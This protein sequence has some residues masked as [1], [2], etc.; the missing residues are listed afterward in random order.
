MEINNSDVKQIEKVYEKISPFE[1]KDKLI[2]IAK[3]D[4]E[5]SKRPLLDAGRG[6][7]NWT[8]ATP[9]QAFFT[10]GQFAVL[11]TQR[12]WKDGD[13]AGMP[14]KNGIYNRFKEFADT[15]INA[16][17]MELLINIIEYG[18]KNKNFDA[19][20]WV[21]ELTDGIIGDN[22]P[23]P[24][25]MLT[26]IESIVHDYLVK[27]MCSSDFESSPF[28]IFA[29]EGATAAM[30]YIFDSL[31]ANELLCKEDRIAII[32]PVFTPYLEI[33]KIPR[34]SLDIVQIKATENP[35][36]GNHSWQVPKEELEKLKDTTIK[37]LFIVNPGNPSS[38]ALTKESKDNLIKI[39]KEDNPNLIIISD[40]VYGT[41]VSKF[42]SLMADLPYNTIG[43][44]S[45]SKY[46]GVTG[47]RLGTIALQKNN[48]LD[49]LIKE[50]PEE[51]KA[52]IRSRY[53][54]LSTNCDNIPFIDRLV[55]DSRQV[56]LNHT[57]GLSTPQ[58]VQMAF[59]CAFSLLDKDDTYKKLT[60][61]ICRRRK[62]LL[63]DG[64]G[65]ELE[66][67]KYSA[68]YYTEFNILKWARDSFGE[69]FAKYL[70]NNYKL[71][72]ILYELAKECSIILLSG[73]GFD[74]SEWSLR[75]SLANLDDHEY[76]TI[77]KVMR[78]LMISLIEEWKQT[79]K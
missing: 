31:K 78:N 69:D 34:Y 43:V 61:E 56:A 71:V 63:F 23:F 51:K 26:H 21:Y 1:F 9:R 4:L 6:N 18:I 41:F 14:H 29:V 28:D 55:A 10:F 38:V 68:Y 60:M 73:S 2:E 25:R 27:E 19:D 54:N 66:D 77:G 15:N 17:G 47:Y 24:D 59:F 75:V 32:T 46:F 65:I 16:P 42:R 8:C 50:L 39:V 49:K 7:P 11:E 72:Y 62:K 35:N 13:L 74:D 3:K 67:N 33:P 44:Y 36:T 64:L 58:Q 37:A 45:F 30:C 40:D 20:S 79:I 12:V 76:Y 22:Y 48:I 5:V 52:L 70:E 57:A 53:K